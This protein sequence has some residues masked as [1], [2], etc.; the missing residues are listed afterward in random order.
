MSASQ[1]PESR[2]LGIEAKRNTFPV[3]IRLRVFHSPVSEYPELLVLTWKYSADEASQLPP[4]AFYAKLEQFERGA[5][6]EAEKR[7]LGLLV[8]VESGLGISRQFYYTKNAHALAMDLDLLIPSSED[9]EFSSDLD[10][11]WKEHHRFVQMATS[12]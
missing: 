2:W 1:I 10:P 4:P 6:D 7:Q 9:V 3:L 11:E 5:V 8:A 12:G